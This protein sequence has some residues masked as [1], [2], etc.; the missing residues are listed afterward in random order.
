MSPD[1]MYGT[2]FEAVQLGNVFPDSKTFVDCV[3]KEAPNVILK[4]FKEQKGGEGFSI[5]QFVNE[6]FDLPKQFAAG[7]KSDTSRTVN[8]HINNL[9]SVFDHLHNKIQNLFV[10]CLFGLCM[11]QDYSHSFD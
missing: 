1:D 8:D 9:W 4:K 2:L 11:Q 5:K 6:N 7:F 3:P 10:Y